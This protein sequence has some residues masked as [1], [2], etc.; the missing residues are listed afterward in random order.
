MCNVYL[1]CQTDQDCS[2][3]FICGEGLCLPGKIWMKTKMDCHRYILSL[4]NTYSIHYYNT[5]FIDPCVLN[6][7]H[8]CHNNGDCMIQS[9]F[10]DVKCNCSDGWTGP[11]CNRGIKI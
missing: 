7:T 10:V 6:G 4:F 9:N 3:D 2:S 8:A 5:Y 11:T 1:E